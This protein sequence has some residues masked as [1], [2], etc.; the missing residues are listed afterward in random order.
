MNSLGKSLSKKYY[1]IGERKFPFDEKTLFLDIFHQSIML[2][3]I[4]LTK[5]SKKK[6]FEIRL[7]LKIIT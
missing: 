6:N 4:I 5:V 7:L 2:L 1:C 3:K